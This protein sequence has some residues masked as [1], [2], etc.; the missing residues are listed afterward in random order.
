[1]KLRTQLCSLLLAGLT[2][3]SLAACS[4]SGAENELPPPSDPVVSDDAAADPIV[5]DDAAGTTTSSLASLLP[6]DFV[7][8]TSVED[9]CLATAGI[10]GDFELL[11]VNGVPITADTY[12]YWMSYHA[13]LQEYTA[14]YYGMELDWASDDSLIA[15]L[16]ETTLNYVLQY[17]LITAKA[18]ELDLELTQEQLDELE[19]SIALAIEDM[20]GEEAFR[21]ALRQYGF[22]YETFYSVNAAAYYYARLRDDLFADRPTAEEMDV[23][24]E[25]N[26]LLAAKHIL[27]MTVDSSTME[28]LDEDT[29]AQKKATAEQLLAQLQSS[30]NLEA[31]FDALMKE[32]SE[33]GGLADNPDGYTFT[34]GDMVAEFENTTRALEYGQ[35]SDLVE[36]PYGYHIILRL[37][38]DTEDQRFDLRVDLLTE[39]VD[40]WISEAEVTFSEE[41]H[42]LDTALYY[43]KYVAYQEAFLA[44]SSAEASGN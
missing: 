16:R 43:A 27:L 15:Y 14:S 3:L 31:D 13:A 40:A 10:P 34:A 9:L 24:I 23:Y 7:V 8:D 32:Y 37:D 41:Y 12:L 19:E 39:Q 2:V 18:K 44:E 35:I 26:D 4:H 20:G 30:T 21:D 6:D 36:T 38:P 17:E 33:D 1:M 25:E 28:P 5:S 22:D 29:I 42:S 11:T